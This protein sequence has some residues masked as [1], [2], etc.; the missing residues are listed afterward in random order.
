MGIRGLQSFL[1]HHGEAIA[2]PQD[3]TQ[4]WLVIDGCALAYF[5]WREARLLEG[6]YRAF[7]TALRLY[8]KQITDAG[9]EM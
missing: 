2:L 1:E 6:G 9:A 8:L 3:G 4:A 5:V 7:A